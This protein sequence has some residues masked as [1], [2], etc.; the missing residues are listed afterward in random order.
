MIVLFS[1]DQCPP[2]SALLLVYHY[3]CDHRYSCVVQ[4]ADGVSRTHILTVVNVLT[5]LS[6]DLPHLHCPN[7]LCA[8]SS[9]T[10]QFQHFLLFFW[11]CFSAPT[12][13]LFVCSSVSIFSGSVWL[14]LSL[15]SSLEVVGRRFGI[16]PLNNPVRREDDL[17]L[18][19]PSPTT[20]S[21][22][23]PGLFFMCS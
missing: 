18:A 14:L 13:C 10:L 17:L 7:S 3:P 23:V 19:L 20:L 4:V 11:I 1:Y 8:N 16:E 5:Y 22:D 6:I 12:C 15:I 2:F 21:D 9:L